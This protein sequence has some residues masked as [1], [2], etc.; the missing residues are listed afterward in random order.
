MLGCV[1]RTSLNVKEIDRGVLLQLHNGV[2]NTE[3]QID[4]NLDEYAQNHAEWMAR[5]E[6]LKHSRLGGE[7]ST[8]GENIAA[9]QSNEQEVFDSWMKSAGHRANILNKQFQYVGFGCAVSRRGTPYWCTVF[10]G[11]Q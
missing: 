6:Y 4:L 5:R 11:N 3:L 7:Y 8:M 10:G 2:R 1:H 9:G